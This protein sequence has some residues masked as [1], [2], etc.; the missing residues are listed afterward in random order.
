MIAPPPPPPHRRRR[1]P[2]VAA[3]FALAG[4]ALGLAG[5]VV[6]GPTAFPG[7]PVAYGGPVASCDTRF[8]VVN[9]SG[10]TI[11][12]IQFSHATLGSWGPD[13]LGQNVLYPGQ[14]VAYQAANVGLYDFRVTW[15]NGAAN[16]LRGVDICRAS[17][18]TAGSD[19][20][21]YAS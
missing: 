4:A 21:L 20:R 15:M 10:A 1:R 6:P 2:A 8:R 18:I 17:Q 11:R 12:S 19:G 16:E 14:S 3:A 9:A 5:C 7:G 13:Q